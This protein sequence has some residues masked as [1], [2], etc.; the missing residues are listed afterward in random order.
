VTRVRSRPGRW[1][2]LLW[3]FEDGS[4]GHDQGAAG[5][6]TGVSAASSRPIAR[7]QVAAPVA[8]QPRS[9]VNSC[10]QCRRRPAEPD[11]HRAAGPRMPAIAAN[12][13]YLGTGARWRQNQRTTATSCHCM[14]CR[15][16]PDRSFSEV[17]ES[18]TSSAIGAGSA[19]VV[20][21]RPGPRPRIARRWRRI[22]L[23]GDN[24]RDQRDDQGDHGDPGPPR[25]QD[26]ARDYRRPGPAFRI[27]A[28]A[29]PCRRA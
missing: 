27:E 11:G 4:Q 5:S 21:T 17:L 20:G 28:G 15:Y 8:Q 7:D 22:V 29:G 25:D 2:D 26:S 12:T 19:T 14:I 3:A 1:R 18:S 24:D 10:W 23:A 16:L 6:W 13:V 9:G